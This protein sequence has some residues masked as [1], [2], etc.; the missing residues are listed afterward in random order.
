[1]SVPIITIDGPSGSGKGTISHLLSKRL[2]WHLL[3]SGAIYRL[4]ALACIDKGIDLDDEN[5][6]YQVSRS[7]EIK[8][9]VSDSGVNILLGNKDVT[10]RIRDE[11]VGMAASTIA[12]YSS[13]RSELLTCQKAFAKM[14]G[15]V[16]DGRD[17]GTVVFKEAKLKF[18]L[19]A[20]AETRADRR[21]KQLAEKGIKAD[22]QEVLDAIKQRDFQDESRTNA[23]L[24]PAKDAILVDSSD[25]TIDEVLHVMLDQARVS[26]LL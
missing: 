15:L 8:F 23:P 25:K 12:A 19:T 10:S 20:S 11:V 7:L 14:P 13:V 2:G 4:C 21:V 18:F 22:Y 26:F 3:D 5:Q 24:K 1:M 6:A 17:M 16:A 9:D